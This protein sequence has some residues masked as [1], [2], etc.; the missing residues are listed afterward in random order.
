MKKILL[1]WILLFFLSWGAEYWTQWWAAA[2]LVIFCLSLLHP[3][4]PSFLL[5]FTALFCL[6]LS[7]GMWSHF[8]TGGHLTFRMARLLPLGGNAWAM[9]AVSAGLGGLCGGLAAASGSTLRRA[10]EKKG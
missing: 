9:L 2:P 5:G 10:L 6:W 4:K 3:K 8:S 1:H 7:L